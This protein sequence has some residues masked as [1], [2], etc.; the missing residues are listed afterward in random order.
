MI[1]TPKFK[2]ENGFFTSAQRSEHMKKIRSKDTKPEV[3]FRKSLWNK[4]IRYRKNV[5]KLSGCPDI[6]IQKYKTVI[7][8][9]GEFWHGY[10]WEEKREKI[11]S[12]RN[13][14]IPKIERNMERDQENNKSLSEM[15]YTVFRFWE[16]EI[17]KDL[18]SCLN[19]VIVY[20]SSLD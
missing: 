15:G 12:N 9:D 14:W 13:F 10:N 11:K 8:I 4:G 3:L 16:H 1:R 7:F 19:K 18:E 20:I 6:V 5:K 2:A 17:K